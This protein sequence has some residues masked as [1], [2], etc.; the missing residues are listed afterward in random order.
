MKQKISIIGAGTGTF[1][2]NLMKDLCLSKGLDESTISLMDI[3]EAKLDAVH[4][5]LTRYAAEAGKHFVIEKTTDRRECLQN[6]DFVINSALVGGYD[7]LFKGWEIAKKLGY[8]FGGSLH[9]L[10]DEAFWTN[11]GQLQLMEEIYAADARF[12]A[13][14]Y[15]VTKARPERAIL[16]GIENSEGYDTLAELAE[17]AKTA[18]AKMRDKGYLVG[19]IGE[20]IFRIVPPL[21]LTESDV[22]GFVSALG[23]VLAEL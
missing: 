14:A 18:G 7:R 21:I 16:V 17:L 23:E 19:T 9:I 22:D 6:A 8:R 5:F 15:E 10:H 13:P 20:R 1:A 2:V 12:L 4:R 3:N 11:F